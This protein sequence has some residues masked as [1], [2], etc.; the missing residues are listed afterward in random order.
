M[1][2]VLM[3]RCEVM[4]SVSSV[5]CF[6]VLVSRKTGGCSSPVGSGISGGRLRDMGDLE[7]AG[8]EEA[9]ETGRGLMAEN[10]E[11]ER[12]LC[13]E[14]S[15]IGEGEADSV[16]EP[17]SMASSK[18]RLNQDASFCQTCRG[19]TEGALGREFKAETM[20]AIFWALRA[21]TGLWSQTRLS[22]SVSSERD[23]FMV[24]SGMS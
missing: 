14:E 21:P 19:D 18:E 8:S 22:K 12:V 3:A 24:D 5:S 13:G 2:G 7:S 17:A 16:S 20:K 11:A 23:Q 15:G 6:L 9:I 4:D 10:G 1:V